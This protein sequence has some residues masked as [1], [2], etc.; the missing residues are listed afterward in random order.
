M[1]MT[2]Q[3]MKKSNILPSERQESTKRLIF[4]KRKLCEFI[5]HLEYRWLPELEFVFCQE[6]Q[7]SHV[8][9][10]IWKINL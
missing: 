8:T 6:S 5:M 9:H 2:A 3:K 7:S 4:F 10:K 1:Y